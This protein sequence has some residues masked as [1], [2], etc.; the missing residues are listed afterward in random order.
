MRIVSVALHRTPYVQ[1]IYLCIL[2][3]SWAVVGG[4]FT[5]SRNGTCTWGSDF[6]PSALNCGIVS[7]L[8]KPAQTDVTRVCRSM[9][10]P[11]TRSILK[12]E[13]AVG[14]PR[15]GGVSSIHLYSRIT[16]RP[17]VW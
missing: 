6:L 15:V 3:K 10:S 14:A 12:S 2:D 13:R 9:D 1:Y 11:G 8:P 4:R 7:V 17:S 5:Q 16:N